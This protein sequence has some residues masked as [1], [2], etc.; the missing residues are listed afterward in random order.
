M[1]ARPSGK[2]FCVVYACA[3]SWESLS[4]LSY[5][6]IE[7]RPYA[8]L[9]SLPP[10]CY[11][12]PCRVLVV[13]SSQ[14]AEKESEHAQVV[15]II[16][17]PTCMMLRDPFLEPRMELVTEQPRTT[18]MFQNHSANLQMYCSWG[19]WWGLGRLMGAP[20]VRP[21]T[22]GSHHD[23]FANCLV[24]ICRSQ[25]RAENYHGSSASA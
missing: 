11:L 19:F 4:W 15:V 3:R 8:L 24:G 9:F 1:G 21:K 2:S 23:K 18:N 6:T 17:T 20:R 12:I 10:C 13:F 7:R 5:Q 22:I 14:R 25:T 16:A